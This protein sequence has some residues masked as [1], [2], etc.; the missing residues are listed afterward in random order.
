MLCSSK[1]AFWFGLALCVALAPIGAYAD[2]IE[3][4]SLLTK[5]E[6]AQGG[7]TYSDPGAMGSSC[8]YEDG[9]VYVFSGP[10]AQAALD[11]L[12]PELGYEE[13]GKVLVEGVGDSA[14]AFYAKAPNQ[15]VGAHAVVVF[16]RGEHR[17][18]LGV[19][20][21]DGQPGESVHDRAVALARLAAERLK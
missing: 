7:P 1:G 8:S 14:F 18:V 19:E 16:S 2:S 20:A 12:L 17:V 15:Y 9:V 6:F 13:S 3:P 4:C 11:S 5:E 10:N 21:E